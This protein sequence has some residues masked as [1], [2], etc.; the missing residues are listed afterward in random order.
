M[1]LYEKK[2]YWEANQ[3]SKFC[4]YIKPMKSKLSPN[5]YKSFQIRQKN[6][7]KNI[8]LKER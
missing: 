4:S 2:N 3:K 7:R 8:F 5:L 6:I 1:D